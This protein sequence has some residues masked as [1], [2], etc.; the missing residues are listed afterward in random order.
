MV[1]NRPSG[2]NAQPTGGVGLEILRALGE[3]GVREG[4]R[5]RLAVRPGGIR[6]GNAGVVQVGLH[7]TAHLP[8][9]RAPRAPRG[10]KIRRDPEATRDHPPAVR[11]GIRQV[12]S[13]RDGL[14]CSPRDGLGCP[15]LVAT[16]RDALA[17][18]VRSRR[19]GGSG[20]SVSIH[21]P[22]DPPVNFRSTLANGR[23]FPRRTAAA[24]PEAPRVASVG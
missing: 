20:T 17:A 6:C 2:R 15:G 8:V 16:R 22:S 7:G 18:I 10:A 19:T 5:A 24:L 4:P 21:F 1:G 9:A 12:V 11:R 3:V 13:P 14:G 23:P